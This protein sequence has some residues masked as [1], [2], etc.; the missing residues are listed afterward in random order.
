[1]RLGRLARAREH[2]WTSRAASAGEPAP[3]VHAW[4]QASRPD[5]RRPSARRRRRISMKKAR[6]ALLLHSPDRM[7]AGQIRAAASGLNAAGTDGEAVDARRRS[8][9]GSRVSLRVLMFRRAV[10][11]RSSTDGEKVCDGL[12]DRLKHE[13]QIYAGARSVAW[14]ACGVTSRRRTQV[15]AISRH[16]IQEGREPHQER[17]QEEVE[18]GRTRLPVRSHLTATRGPATVLARGR[19]SKATGTHAAG[20]STQRSEESSARSMPNIA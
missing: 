7:S 20:P 8:V 18:T 13:G 6:S 4:D 2:R 19:Q 17:F 1:M 12:F 5:S 15:D 11:D 10:K 16:P 14:V 9:S 3:L